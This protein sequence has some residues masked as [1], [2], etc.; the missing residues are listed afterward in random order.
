MHLSMGESSTAVRLAWRRI[1]FLELYL[2]SPVSL[3]AFV[4]IISGKRSGQSITFRRHAASRN[5]TDGNQP[6]LDGIGPVFGKH[7]VGIRPADVVGMPLDQNLKTGLLFSRAANLL[8]VAVE[9]GLRSYLPKIEQN[10]GS[11]NRA[12]LFVVFGNRQLLADILHGAC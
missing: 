8:S 3:A 7:M 5:S 4:G 10:F 11:Q 2:H 12:D 6:S 1:Q 9:A